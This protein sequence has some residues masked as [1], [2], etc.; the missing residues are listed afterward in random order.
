MRSKFKANSRQIQGK[1]NAD[2][3]SGDRPKPHSGHPCTGCGTGCA[4]W[5][6]VG[7]VPSVMLTVMLLTN[8]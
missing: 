8:S 3:G 5:T 4:L 6:G 7:D 2:D 1:F